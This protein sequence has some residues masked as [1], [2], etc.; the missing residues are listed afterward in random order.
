MRQQPTHALASLL[1]GLLCLAVSPSFA[2]EAFVTGFEVTPGSPFA[3]LPE[4][5]PCQILPAELLC[6]AID[7]ERQVGE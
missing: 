3:G 7:L 5:D 1:A 2:E 4:L 6:T